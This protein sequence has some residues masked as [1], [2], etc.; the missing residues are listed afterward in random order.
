MRGAARRRVA[1]RT[2]GSTVMAHGVFDDLRVFL[3]LPE[4]DLSDRRRCGKALTESRDILVELEAEPARFWLLSFTNAKL[5]ALE[6]P[7]SLEGLVIGVSGSR[8]AELTVVIADRKLVLEA[9]DSAPQLA[10]SR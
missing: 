1:R 4:F 6:A 7:R 5:L 2:L 8:A 10:E 9:K 3:G